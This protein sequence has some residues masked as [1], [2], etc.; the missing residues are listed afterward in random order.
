MPF[1]LANWMQQYYRFYTRYAVESWNNMSPM[2]YGMVLIGVFLFGWL[3]MKS[4]R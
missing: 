3:L 4:N 2:Q 1:V